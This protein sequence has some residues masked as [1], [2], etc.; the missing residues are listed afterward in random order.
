MIKML[1]T[2][3]IFCKII[4]NELPSKK[5]YEDS[6]CLAF[7]DI[8]PISEGHSIVIPKQHFKNIEDTPPDV[9]AN[10]FLAVKMIST[11]LRFRLHLDGYNIM[12]NNFKAAGQVINHIHVHIIP[13]SYG[14]DKFK[15]KIPRT[16][17]SENKL[18]EVANLLRD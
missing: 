11:K 18:N 16:Q 15:L 12:Q 13:R 3:C 7:L 5:I 9:L 8:N 17:I 4:Q 6:T 1:K 14:D 10:L 2:D